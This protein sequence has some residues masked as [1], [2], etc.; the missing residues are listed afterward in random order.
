MIGY[1][2]YRDTFGGRY[3][4]EIIPFLR[5]AYM[6]IDGMILAAEEEDIADAVCAQAEAMAD[7]SAYEVRLGDYS[8]KRTQGTLLCDEARCRLEEAGLIYRGVM[9]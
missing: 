4:E 3:G 7:G 8:E 6:L 5:R 2:Y 1:G 9:T